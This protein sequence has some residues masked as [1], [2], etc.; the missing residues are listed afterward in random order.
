MQVY[1]TD[2]VVAMTRVGVLTHLGRSIQTAASKPFDKVSIPYH[3][4]LMDILI[5]KSSTAFNVP[6]MPYTRI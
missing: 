1:C 5:W 6:D 2:S 4:I 3:N